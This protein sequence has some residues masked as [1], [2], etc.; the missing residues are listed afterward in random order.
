MNTHVN[1]TIERALRPFAPQEESPCL[2]GV[3]KFADGW[4]TYWSGTIDDHPFPNRTAAIDELAKRDRAE[5]FV[6]RE[7]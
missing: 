2:L 6:E 5:R 3:V 4:H 7:G 1:E